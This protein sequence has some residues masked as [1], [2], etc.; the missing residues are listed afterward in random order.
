M[1]LLDHSPAAA[2]WR[3]PPV[4]AG[5]R[6]DRLP[7]SRWLTKVMIILFLGWLVESYDI[8]LSGSV[9]PSPSRFSARR[10]GAAPWRRSSAPP[11]AAA[12]HGGGEPLSCCQ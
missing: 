9:L 2:G 11:S 4:R 6:L 12:H 10:P 8:G 3:E 5:A 7:A 1:A